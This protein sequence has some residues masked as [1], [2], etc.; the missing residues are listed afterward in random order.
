MKNIQWQRGPPPGRSHGSEAVGSCLHSHR[1][2]LT[3]DHFQRKYLS[4][5]FYLPKF[6]FV[7][8]KQTRKH[9]LIS[10]F[11]PLSIVPLG[12]LT[13]KQIKQKRWKIFP[14]SA[15]EWD[16]FR[17]IILQSRDFLL[18]LLLW[19]H[20]RR[21]KYPSVQK[22]TS[23]QKSRHEDIIAHVKD[24]AIYLNPPLQLSLLIHLYQ[25]FA[26]MVCHNNLLWVDITPE[27]LRLFAS[28]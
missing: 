27:L 6:C 15:K 16:C 25:T 23:V 8:Q 22:Y 4:F 21:W 17:W 24:F 5:F 10:A 3:I 9:K 28:Q 19:P 18:T 7:K 13:A 26:I 20:I 12:N 14:K 1:C 11:T 2:H